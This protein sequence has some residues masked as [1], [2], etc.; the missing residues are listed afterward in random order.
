MP[1]VSPKQ[2]EKEKLTRFYADFWKAISLLQNKQQ[3]HDFFFDLLTHTERKMLAKRFQVALM[4][5][6]G[7]DYQTIRDEVKVANATVTKVNNWL[8]TGADELIRVGRELIDEGKRDEPSP[9]KKKGRY[10]AGDLLL[11]AIEEG[12]RLVSQ[13]IKGRKRGI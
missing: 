7:K 11:P 8:K 6:Q 3:V 10:V 1:R 4:L 2:V 13:K 12:A 9:T 5:L